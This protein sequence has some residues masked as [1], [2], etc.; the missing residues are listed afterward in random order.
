M[1]PGDKLREL[2][3]GTRP[4]EIQR[5]QRDYNALPP[6]RPLTVTGNLDPATAKAVDVA[7]EAREMFRL[8]REGR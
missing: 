5:F 8:M 7:F 6:A 2:G 4:V 1:T 3:Y